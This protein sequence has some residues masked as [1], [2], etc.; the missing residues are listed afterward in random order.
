MA[1]KFNKTTRKQIYEKTK[2]RC[3]Y[4]GCSIRYGAMQVDHLIPVSQN[5]TNDIKNLL[6][7]CRSCNH[8]KGSSTLESFREQV[9][10]FPAVLARDSVTYRNAVRFG[11]VLPNPQKVKFYFELMEMKSYGTSN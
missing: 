5:G 7:A 10:R 6:P 2:G 1:G 4:C 9:E 3:A 11:L 8:R